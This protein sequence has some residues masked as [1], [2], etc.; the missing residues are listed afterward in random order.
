MKRI[1]AVILLIMSGNLLADRV[2]ELAVSFG[3]DAGQAGTLRGVERCLYYKECDNRYA[4]SVLKR[5]LSPS[6]SPESAIM[7]LDRAA[8]VLLEEFKGLYPLEPDLKR[9]MAHLQFNPESASD[10][11]VDMLASGLLEEAELAE[12]SRLI[13]KET[14]LTHLNLNNIFKVRPEVAT[15]FQ[16]AKA[17]A[18]IRLK[19]TSAGGLAEPAGVAV[20]REYLG[21]V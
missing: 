6:F 20:W 2:D 21:L 14:V 3:L 15:D 4:Q 9:A 1:L 17:E 8:F 12:I 10:I 13:D 19:R 11:Y 16:K 7:D 18:L 5:V